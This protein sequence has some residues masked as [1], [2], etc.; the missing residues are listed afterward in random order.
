MELIAFNVI[1]IDAQGKL[2]LFAEMVHGYKDLNHVMMAISM[3]SMV[4]ILNVI[5]NK[6]ISVYW[7]TNSHQVFPCASTP[8]TSP[9]MC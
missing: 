1:K 8:K 5:L 9:S 3:T 4:V 7:L 6:I 2:F